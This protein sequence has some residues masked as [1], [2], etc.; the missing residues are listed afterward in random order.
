[1]ADPHLV[2]YIRQHAAAFGP[3]VLRQHLAA[4]GVPPAE[5]EAALTE[6]LPVMPPLVAVPA[7]PPPGAV[8][9]TV[10]PRPRRASRAA[11]AVGAL[12]GGLGL[13]AVSFFMGRQPAAP[14]PGAGGGKPAA[15]AEAS[16]FHGSYDFI[17]KLPAGYAASDSFSDAE[18]T[19]E[20]V[21]VYPQGTDP[22]HFIDDGLYDHLGI[23]RLE[24]LPR[25]VPQ[26]FIGMDTLKQWVTKQLDADKSLYEP[27]TTVVNGMPA[28]IVKV[29]R[30]FQSRKAYLVGEK[31]RYVLVG[32]YENPVF[33]EVLQTLAETG[34]RGSAED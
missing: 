14:R 3:E 30:P 8:P 10:P 18:R 13:M 2:D 1:M 22:Q 4:Q 24:V 23:L 33:D 28:F 12:A 25:R 15:P 17:L 32:G 16:L 9:P 31:V 27:K 19:M 6:A 21:Y 26:G 34:G 11:V 29:S 5:V 20:V 7:P